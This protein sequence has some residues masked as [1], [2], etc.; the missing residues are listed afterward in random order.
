[1]STTIKISP[2]F[3][4]STFLK[5]TWQQKPKLLKG[6][7][8]QSSTLMSPEEL[9]GLACEEFLDSR[10]VERK[11]SNEVGT[12]WRLRNGPFQESDF[13]K[14]PE[15]NWTLLVQSI[16]QVNEKIFKLQCLFN[17]IPRWRVDDVMVSFAKPGGGV[18]PHFDNYDVF[19]VQ[20]QGTRKW[21]IGQRCGY[22]SPLAT[23][24]DLSLLT[25]FKASQEFFLEEGD[26]LYIPPKFSHWGESLDDSICYSVGFRAPSMT[27]MLQGFTD[28]LAEDVNPDDRFVDQHKVVPEN[29]TEISSTDLHETFLTIKTLVNDKEKFMTW[30]GCHMTQAKYPELIEASNNNQ[31]K[32]V[33]ETSTLERSPFSRFAYSCGENDKATLFVD[34]EAFVLNKSYKQ[35]IKKIC[36]AEHIE[37]SK[38]DGY[39]DSEI[40]R[41]TISSLC[42]CGSLLIL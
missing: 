42:A 32:Q 3:D 20:G 5:E 12:A 34:G 35:S 40:I 31:G 9:A 22:D 13:T 19:L 7:I 21:K 1:M 23:G 8:Q 29:I 11:N 25:N 26:A 10:I 14:M 28:F 41:K 30:F 16:D 38:L 18:G 4:S 15:S 37:I 33:E 39:L 24:T 17:F 6:F 2:T 36:E 27:D